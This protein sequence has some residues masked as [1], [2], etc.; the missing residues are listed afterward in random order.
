MKKFKLYE[1]DDQMMSIIRDDYSVLQMLSA[2][3]IKMGFG[4]K[5][6]REVCESEGV[7]TYTFMTIVN[8][9][10]NGFLD[11]DSIERLSVPTLLRY[12]K[13][14]HTYFCDFEL[15]FIRRELEESLNDNDSLAK[16]IMKLYDNYAQSI[17]A[18][19]KYEEKTMF[20]YVEALIDGN[21]TNSAMVE[22][23]SRNHHQ[24]DQKLRELK[25][26]IIKYLPA[27]GRENNSLSHTLYDIYNTER[28]IQQHVRIE[29]QILTPAILHLEHQCKQSDVSQRIS[30]MITGNNRKQEPLSDRERDVIIGVV[31]GMSNKQI[32]DHLCIAT[33]TV[34][35]HRRNIAKKLQIHTPAGLTI[36]AIVNNLVDIESVKL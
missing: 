20:P 7:D 32:A 36:Y 22:T 29:D 17:R 18:H 14:A 23:F 34:T 6:V 10:A 4:D 31:Q 3:G 26:I 15:P 9:A 8:F 2:F 1:Q 5:S 19:M 30:S 24:T 12:L 27:S 35:T 25:Q 21:I 16:L 28:W 13:A 33:N 11:P